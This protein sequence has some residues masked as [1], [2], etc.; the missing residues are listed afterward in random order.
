METLYNIKA[1]ARN[2]YSLETVTIVNDAVVD[3]VETEPTYL[4][5][6]LG[7]LLAKLAK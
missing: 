6:V 4:P 5:I 3:R 1:Q 2:L 7:Q